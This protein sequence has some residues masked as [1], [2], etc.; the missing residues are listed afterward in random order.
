LLGLINDILDMSKIEAG[1]LAIEAIPFEVV[2]LVKLVHEVL[3][4]SAE[5]RG[6]NLDLT[7]NP[8]SSSLVVGDPLRVRQVLTNLVANAI[9][10]TPSQGEVEL[11]VS[12]GLTPGSCCFSVRDTGM[13]IDLAQQARLFTPFS[14]VDA[15]TTRRFG[16][17]GLGLSISRELARLMGGDLIVES[18]VG[19]GSTFHFDVPFALPT[20][21]QRGAFRSSGAAT[22]VPMVDVGHSLKGLRVLLVEDNRV[23]QLLARKLLEKVGVVVTLA[24]NG[25]EAVEWVCELKTQFDA[26]LM[27]IQMPQMDGYEATRVILGRLGA[28][29]PPIFALTA[30]AMSSETARCVAAGMRL[31][32]TKPIDVAKLYAV[33][34]TC[35]R[36]STG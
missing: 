16:G 5:A 9:K 3:A 18:A 23:N 31:T 7:V 13:G 26:I 14:Q 29:A 32:L 28:A 20:P 11:V 12:Q 15:S 21:E 10:F 24:G 17:T 33:L 19:Q 4:P 8:L 25:L 22:P 6:L 36:P 27:D 30:H 35:T 34:A 1:H 2:E